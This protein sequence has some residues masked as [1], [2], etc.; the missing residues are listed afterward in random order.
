MKPDD[1][2]NMIEAK[3]F[4]DRRSRRLPID[5]KRLDEYTASLA[6]DKIFSSTLPPLR[7]ISKA[8]GTFLKI[9]FDFREADIFCV[10]S[11]SPPLPFAFGHNP[12]KYDHT[13]QCK[14]GDFSLS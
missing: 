11:T 13:D 8:Y 10:S 6:N 9:E 2:S 14:T 7:I 5:G 1:L 3:M 12:Y 4:S